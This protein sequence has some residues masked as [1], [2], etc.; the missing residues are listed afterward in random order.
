MAMEKLS[1]FPRGSHFSWIGGM[2]W[3]GEDN[4]FDE[5]SKAIASH[6]IVIARHS[7]SLP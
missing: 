6:G 1:Q 3:D 4:A 5:I 2:A 7:Q